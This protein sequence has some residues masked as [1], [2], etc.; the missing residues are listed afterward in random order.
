MDPFGTYAASAFVEA[1]REDV[2]LLREAKVLAGIEVRGLVL[3]TKTGVVSELEMEGEG[4]G[5]GLKTEG[6]GGAEM[7]IDGEETLL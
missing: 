4:E 6:D 1:L 5:E 7:K 2:R 3:D